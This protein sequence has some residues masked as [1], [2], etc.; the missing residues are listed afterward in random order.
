MVT[1]LQTETDF[2]RLDGVEKVA[3]FLFIVLNATLFVRP[4]EIVPAWAE[5]PIY[6]WVI[7]AC[8]FFSYPAILRKLTAGDLRQDPVTFCLI[9][10]FVMVVLSHLV[11]SFLWGAR[12]F[13]FEFLKVLLYY[14]LLVA[15]VN[16]QD[17][18]HGLLRWLVLFNAVAAVLALLHYY[19]V[20]DIP[21]LTAYAQK[22]V[23]LT[24]GDI[25]VV[26]R[27][28][29]TGMFNDP[30]DLC[31]ALNVAFLAALYFFF[32][33]EARG[34]QLLWLSLAALFGFGIVL[35]QSRGGMLALMGGLVVFGRV[36]FGWART[37]PFAA[38]VLPV[39]ALVLA[40]RSTAITLTEDTAQD[41]LQLW[42]MA[43]TMFREQPVFGVGAGQ[44]E[45]QVGWVAH[46]SFVHNFTELG[47]IGGAL[48]LGAFVAAWWPLYRAS[49]EPEPLADERAERLKAY[50]LAMLTS[51]AVGILTLSRMY[52]PMTYLVLGLAAS[53]LAT[54]GVPEW[55]SALRFDGRF[56][57]TVLMISAAFLVGVYVYVR[58]FVRWT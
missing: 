26:P 16:T 40:Q 55:R 46:N 12:Y 22:Q 41:R 6:N 56:A 28:Q 57:R 44:Y 53:F 2:E 34:G 51:Y 31:L 10:V 54:A 4:A 27:L 11:H 49:L 48:F 47:I 7:V 32:D 35:T 15:V 19:E 39:L 36:R 20:I 3:Y 37:L 17:R 13:G 21:A 5:L 45:E 29:G 58:L 25:Y 1:A 33:P 9:G 43:L 42:S 38:A 14:L 18:L 30:N 23:D 52:V 50:V 24:T 8:L